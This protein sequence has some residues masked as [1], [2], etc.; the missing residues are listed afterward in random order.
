MGL[1]QFI[2]IK[3]KELENK[4]GEPSCKCKRLFPSAEKFY[5]GDISVQ[6][7]RNAYNLHGYIERNFIRRKNLILANRIELDKEQIA[8]FCDKADKQIK[9]LWKKRDENDSNWTYLDWEKV[10]DVLKKASRILEKDPD[11]KI[12]Y[13][14]F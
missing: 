9:F 5:N 14:W 13:E 8:K 2:L 11:A 7:W 3:S 12:Y 6:R 4:K 1:D 10:R